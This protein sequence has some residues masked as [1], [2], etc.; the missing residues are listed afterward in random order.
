VNA[1]YIRVEDNFTWLAF[2]AT[3]TVEAAGVW[4]LGLSAVLEETDGIK[5]YWAL[6]HPNAEKPDF[7]DSACFAAH[8]P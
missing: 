3:I 4:E 7:H 5:S 6:A 2:G 8:L 1:P